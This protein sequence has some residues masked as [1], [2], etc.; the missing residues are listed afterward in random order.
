VLWLARKLTFS[1]PSKKPSASNYQPVTFFTNGNG[2][3]PDAVTT[4]AASANGKNGTGVTSGTSGMSGA[5]RGIP[6]QKPLPRMEGGPPG[7]VKSEIEFHP[8]NPNI[9]RAPGTD[10]DQ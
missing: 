6:P 5:V 4:G 9:A 1:E 3:T 8:Q 10:K 2:E 7:V